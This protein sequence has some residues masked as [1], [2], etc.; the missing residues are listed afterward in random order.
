M[1]GSAVPFIATLQMR[2]KKYFPNTQRAGHFLCL[3][4]DD[5]SVCDRSSVSQRHNTSLPH[6]FALAA[7]PVACT[8]PFEQFLNESRTVTYWTIRTRILAS[9]AL[10]L[11]IMT[12]MGVVAFNRMSAIHRESNTVPKDQLP[13]LH[14]STSMRA[15]WSELYVLGW[16]T[17][18]ASSGEERGRFFGL[19]R[20]AKQRL[21]TLEQS[22]EAIIVSDDDRARFHAYKA[23]RAKYEQASSMFSQS[24]A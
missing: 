11:L 10:I 13:G 7:T 24:I 15:A 12:L 16:Q 9:F 17:A 8:K 6:T 14:F 20:E 19:T 23:I 18:I 4:I 3:R 2:S 21:N 1:H 22:Y 5:A